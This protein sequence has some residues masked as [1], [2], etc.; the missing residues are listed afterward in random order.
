MLHFYYPL[1]FAYLIIL[2]ALSIRG[3][4]L[5]FKQKSVPGLVFLAALAPAWICTGLNI[6]LL[7][8]NNVINLLEGKPFHAH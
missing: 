5:F 6:G 1:L 3:A 4:Y 7:A 2:T 8:A